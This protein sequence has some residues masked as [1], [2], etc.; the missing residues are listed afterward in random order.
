MRGFIDLPFKV[1]APGARLSASVIFTVK[2]LVAHPYRAIKRVSKREIEG[3]CMMKNKDEREHS[4]REIG[5]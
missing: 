2:H 5:T 1:L 4:R 3:V